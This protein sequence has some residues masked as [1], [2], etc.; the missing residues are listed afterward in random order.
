MA[1]KRIG[2]DCDGVIC[3]FYTGYEQAIINVTGRDLFPKRAPGVYPPV[4]DWPQLYGYSDTELGPVWEVICDDPNFWADLGRL[5]DWYPT[6]DL[7]NDNHH[8]IY[9]ITA[10]P[11]ITA[12]DQTYRWLADQ[13]DDDHSGRVLISPHKGICADA[14]KLDVYV[15]DRLEN[16]VDV[17]KMS[18]QTHAYLIDRPYNQSTRILRRVATLQ[19]VI[20]QEKL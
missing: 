9:F 12:M 19:D 8:D 11:S 7:L 18:P 5:S 13:I 16:I 6:W 15:D 20:D 2:L 1:R 10:R 4:W 17:E 14:L 3:D